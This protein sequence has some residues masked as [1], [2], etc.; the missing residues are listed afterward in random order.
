MFST[1]QSLCLS[2]QLD[3]SVC[4]FGCYCLS[5]CIS[6]S[7]YFNVSVFRSAK[8]FKVWLFISLLFV[9]L[10]FRLLARACFYLQVAYIYQSLSAHLS[11]DYTA[12]PPT[13]E[14]ELGSYFQNKQK[15][16]VAFTIGPKKLW[17]IDATL[18]GLWVTRTAPIAA[19]A[20][21]R[22]HASVMRTVSHCVLVITMIKADVFSS[23]YLKRW[24]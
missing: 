21:I 6:V 13:T 12:C 22:L 19:A 20:I 8:S 4:L 18:P 23:W 16:P 3:P 15:L 17:K 5:V 11:V 24:K 7:S 2:V 10:S 1:C 14:Q 9:H